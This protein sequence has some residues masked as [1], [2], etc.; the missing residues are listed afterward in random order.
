MAW[1]DYSSAPTVGTR[2][3]DA[4]EI[5]GVLSLSL[6]TKNGIFPMLVMRWGEDFRAY[7]NACPHQ[8]L[9]LDYHGGQLLSAD[10]T[11]LLC[12]VHG[13]RFA[14]DT[15][16]AVDGAECGLD[17]VPVVLRNGVLIVSG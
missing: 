9:P 1:T 17:A 3:C 15:G 13:A 11:K 2:I 10:G 7:V 6:Q 4:A 8:Y 16:D 12:T 14:I 5:D